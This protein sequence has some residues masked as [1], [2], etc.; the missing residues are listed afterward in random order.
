METSILRTCLKLRNALPE[1]VFSTFAC[2]PAT[3][4][5]PA[6]KAAPPPV[7]EP[8]TKKSAMAKGALAERINDQ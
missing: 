4:T 5:T 2:D 3:V 8:E 1:E 7:T 6:A